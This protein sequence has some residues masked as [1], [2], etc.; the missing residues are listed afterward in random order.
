MFV[1]MFWAKGFWAKRMGSVDRVAAS[2]IVRSAASRVCWIL[3][4]CFGLMVLLAASG[5]GA[6][7]IASTQTASATQPTATTPMMSAAPMTAKGMMDSM[8]VH[9]QESAVHRNRYSYLSNERSDRTG[10]HLWTERVVE[11]PQ[12]RVRMLLAVDGVALNAEQVVQERG[13]LAEI[14]RDPGP[15]LKREKA[16]K[17]D[18]E[19][20]RQL[21]QLLPKAFLF[22]N[23]RPEGEYVRID[24]R[25]NPEYQ[26]QSM[27]ERVMHGMSGSL[28]IDPK[29]MRMH[30]IEA[31]LPEDVSIGFGIL[32]TIRA[33]TNFLTMRQAVDSDEWKTAVVDTKIDGRALFFKT[34]SRSEHAE[35]TDFHR[36][37]NDLT[38]VQAVA[39]AEQ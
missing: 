38:L 11:T 13:R 16:Q 19:Q 28:L 31:R 21:L 1:T 35:H 18:E 34:L 5:L 33:G 3:P 29:V 23:M 27:Q 8:I 37:P 36:V 26:T 9:E 20:A 39:L 10:G 12:G 17:S 22:E 2:R 14:L 7:T 24:F 15:F 30:R 25:P 4:A 32:A 6:Q